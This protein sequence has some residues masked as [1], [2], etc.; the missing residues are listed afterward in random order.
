MYRL[1]FPWPR[2]QWSASRLG[3]F[4]LHRKSSTVPIA[5]ESGR[6]P[7]SVWTT[8]K[9]YNSCTYWDSNSEPSIIQL[10]TSRYADSAISV[11]ISLKYIVILSIHLHL[12]ICSGFFPFGFPTKVIRIPL[13]PVRAIC[14]AHLIVL[15]VIIL[16][17]LGKSTSSG[18]SHYAAFSELLSLNL[19]S[20][21]LFSSAPYSQIHS[22]YVSLLMSEA[23][24]H[25]H[26]E[27]QAKW[28]KLSKNEDSRREEKRFWTKWYT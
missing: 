1:T 27:P 3:S 13:L 8:R 20:A 2:N 23:M 5:L 17:I 21:Q 24:F 18:A 7:E 15:G 12:G 6:A 10:V 25:T 14:P 22:V 9:K 19:S 28:S 16:I 26:T 11:V 4:N